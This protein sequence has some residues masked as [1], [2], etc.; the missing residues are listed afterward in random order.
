LALSRSHKEKKGEEEP[1][2]RAE[3]IIKILTAGK[4][5]RREREGLGGQRKASESRTK[6][7]RSWTS[8]LTVTTNK[9]EKNL[10]IAD[11]KVDALRKREEQRRAPEKT[12]C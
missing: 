10:R 5:C 11:W 2:K 12:Q 1:A 9:R 6:V 4:K 7:N 3:R 8:E